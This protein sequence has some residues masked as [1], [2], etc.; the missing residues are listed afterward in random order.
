MADQ[1]RNQIQ[2]LDEKIQ[3]QLENYKYQLIQ[4]EYINQVLIKQLD[5]KVT[6]EI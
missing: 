6:S 1:A 3:Y 4:Q 5:S 2:D